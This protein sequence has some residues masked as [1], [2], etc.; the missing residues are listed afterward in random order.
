MISQKEQFLD[1]I[2]QRV[3]D[4]VNLDVPS[5]NATSILYPLARE[6]MKRPLCM[7]AA[8]LLQ[9]KVKRGDVVLIAT[10]F[11]ERPSVSP[12]IGETDGPPGAAALARAIYRGLSAVPILLVEKQFVPSMSMIMRG[13]GL[14][15]LAPDEAIT[16]V[17]TTDDTPAAAVLDFPVDAEE[18]KERAKQLIGRYKPS[19]I[20][21][22]EKAGMNDRGVSHSM[23]GNPNTII[24]KADYLVLEAAKQGIPTI[25]VGDGGNEIGM[26]V[27]VQ[28][29]RRS[30]IP[31][32][33]KCKCPCGGGI[34]CA[35]S[36]DVLV[37]ACISNWGA[38]GIAACLAARLQRPDV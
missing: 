21:V 37:T 20:I 16:A 38:Y 8:S 19:A 14:L 32:I 7:A 36:T 23:G 1:T 18:A 17:R 6:K 24:A 12:A 30:S 11:T 25:G 35:T 33:A 34:A 31:N 10:G 29:L 5:R 15:A 4:L 22:I 26:G 2:G 27:I 28:E 9:A 13:A 3:D